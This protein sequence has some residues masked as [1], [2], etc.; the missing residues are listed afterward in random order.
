MTAAQRPLEVMSSGQMSCPG[1]GLAL[2]M[3]QVMRAM[4][5]RCVVVVVPSC[6]A[7][8]TGPDPN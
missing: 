1:C 4:G 5:K 6:V 3:R 2:G 8:T 7:V